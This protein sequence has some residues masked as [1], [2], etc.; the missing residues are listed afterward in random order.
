VPTRTP[1][2]TRTPRPTRTSAS[3][4]PSAT[5]RLTAVAVLSDRPDPATPPALRI[6]LP[7]ALLSGVASPA[8]AYRGQAGSPY[9]YETPTTT[10]ATPPTRTP[11]SAIVAGPVAD[12][13]APLW[14]FVA[15][16]GISIVVGCVLAVV[17]RTL[18]LAGGP[19]KP[20]L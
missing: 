16:G 12:V 1:S 10:R 8:A 6:I 7:A 18:R 13:P 19:E 14:P 11:I 9:R 17:D 20:V 4:V 5:P 3:L 2:P 15:G